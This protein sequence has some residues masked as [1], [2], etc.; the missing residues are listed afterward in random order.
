MLNLS[1]LSRKAFVCVENEI[2]RFAQQPARALK[3]KK[4]L[5]SFAVLRWQ[6]TAIGVGNQSQICLRRFGTLSSALPNRGIKCILL[7]PGQV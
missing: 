5:G 2:E 4:A 1:C 3:Q 7:R 6:E